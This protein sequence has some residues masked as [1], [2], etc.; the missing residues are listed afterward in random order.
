MWNVAKGPLCG[1]NDVV[2]SGDGDDVVNHAP[3]QRHRRSG[4]GDDDVFVLGLDDII[5]TGDGYDELTLSGAPAKADLATAET[6]SGTAWAADQDPNV[7][8]ITLE[9]R[10]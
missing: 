6:I 2:V 1:F 7:S 4:G 9:R 8:E 10:R 3:P 5:S